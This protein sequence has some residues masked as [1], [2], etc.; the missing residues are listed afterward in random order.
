MTNVVWPT[1]DSDLPAF[2]AMAGLTLTDTTQGDLA[3]SAAIATFKSNVR[4]PIFLAG[5]DAVGDIDPTEPF[6][7]YCTP[8]QGFIN[9]PGF[10]NITEVKTGL[11]YTNGVLDENS[12]MVVYE[13]NTYESGRQPD[14]TGPVTWI[15]LMYG[16]HP[17]LS[18]SVTGL[19]GAYESLP[20]D[21]FMAVLQLATMKLVPWLAYKDMGNVAEF[22]IGNQDLRVKFQDGKLQVLNDAR[23]DILSSVASY[24]LRS[25]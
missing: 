7:L 9:L 10:I 2:L 17:R 24:K 11:T 19:R 5:V 22:E 18:V 12:G 6:T 20:E 25:L 1:A 15:Q 3:L 4:F 13:P 8:R 14:F 16:C 21:V 23:K